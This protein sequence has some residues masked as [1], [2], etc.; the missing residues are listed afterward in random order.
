MSQLL[1]DGKY[2]WEKHSKYL[3]ILDP[4]H[5]GMGPNGYTT[6]PAKMFKHDTFTI[7]EG[8]V[9]RDI[10]NKL[11]GM[12]QG[13]R[14][15]YAV[16]ADDI[17]DTPLAQ[18]VSKADAIYGKD[19]RAIYL[20]IHSNSGGGSGN[21]IFTSP[22]Q[23]KSDKIANIFADTYQKHF[24]DFKFRADK[25]DGDADKEADFYVLRKTDCPAIL[26]ENLFF[27]NKK[28]AE[29]LLSEEGQ[30]RI[31]KCLFDAIMMCEQLKPI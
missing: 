6:A 2:L 20:S 5:G 30:I 27:D 19:K 26:V 1:L 28:E 4:G 3:W 18:R 21:E 14:I 8:V 29:F 22:G 17:E 9:N 11:I 10:T 16:V 13:A 7:Y 12:L 15:D 31:A 24:H 25:S 23:T